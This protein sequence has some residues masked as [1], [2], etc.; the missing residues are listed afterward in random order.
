MINKM[1][2]LPK[3]FRNLCSNNAPT[4]VNITANDIYNYRNHQ[5]IQQYS[6]ENK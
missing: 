4:I 3:S 5:A 1:N 6:T 2:L